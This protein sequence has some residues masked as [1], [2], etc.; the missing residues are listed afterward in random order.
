MFHYLHARAAVQQTGSNLF[1]FS[2]VDLLHHNQYSVS[3]P[4]GSPSPVYCKFFTQTRVRT[5]VIFSLVPM[6]FSLCIVLGMNFRFLFVLVVL[7]FLIIWIAREKDAYG[8]IFFFSLIR[9]FFV[10]YNKLAY[11]GQETPKKSWAESLI[12]KVYANHTVVKNLFF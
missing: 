5:E 9:Y 10:F 1:S 4:S 11:C 2:Y 12:E 3:W 7:Q 6:L 8:R